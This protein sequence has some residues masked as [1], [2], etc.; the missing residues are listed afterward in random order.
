MNYRKYSMNIAAISAIAFTTQFSPVSASGMSTFTIASTAKMESVKPNLV[1]VAAEAGSFQTLLT[2]AKAAGLADVLQSKGP[3]TVLAPSDEAF[4]KLLPEGSVDRLLR[5]ENKEELVNILKYHVLPGRLNAQDVASLPA[6]TTVNGQS[7][8]IT[9]N[10][11]NLR[12][13]AAL[14]KKAD[15]HASNGVIHV[16]DRVLTPSSKTIVDVAENAN[17]FVSLIAALKA[18]GLDT[19]LMGEGPLTV[20]A[21]TDRAF[22]ALPKGTVSSLLKEENLPKLKE[23]LKY[24]VIPGRIL[25]SELSKKPS[26]KTLNGQTLPIVASA[27]GIRLGTARVINGDLNTSNGI[28]HIIDSVLIPSVEDHAQRD[29]HVV[30]THSTEKMSFQASTESII[31]KAIEVGA[32]LYNQHNAKAC[33]DVYSLAAESLVN[34]KIPSQFKVELSRAIQKANRQSK[35]SDR[36][37]TYR[38]AFDKVLLLS[39][40]MTSA[41]SMIESPYKSGL[42]YAY[43]ETP[44]FQ[45]IPD[46]SALKP[47]RT[48]F[49]NVIEIDEVSPRKNYFAVQFTGKIF[50]EQA[51]EWEFF[52]TSDDGSK[53]TINGETWID[54]D[55]IH[56]PK[57]VSRKLNLKA[58]FQDIQVDYFQGPGGKKLQLEYAGPGVARKSVP[59]ARLYQGEGMNDMAVA[60]K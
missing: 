33:A 16:I 15:I 35:A 4:S 8:S 42:R 56:A 55:G 3:F 38:H 12:F 11:S 57:T 44:K 45:Q 17:E 43:Y 10:G 29:A 23:I 2:A 1:E 58:G 52:L 21:P 51:G 40:E 24:H 49:S 59:A 36:A 30:K 22:S 20:L 47:K 50:L 53:L 37:W 19:A 31:H 6:A 48:G 54:L 41:T 13:N 28:V 46:F 14:V 5:P 32:P 39:K 27:R 34:M 26:I 7:V 18:T 9:K 60:S 25:S